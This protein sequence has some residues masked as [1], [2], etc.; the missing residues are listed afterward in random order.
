MKHLHLNRTTSLF[1]LDIIE[2]N[3]RKEKFILITF[4][5]SFYI[6]YEL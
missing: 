6:T 4:Q 3:K 5:F 2:P 1:K